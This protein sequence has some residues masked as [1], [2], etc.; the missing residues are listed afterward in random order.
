[1]AWR[2]E[3]ALQKWEHNRITHADD[4]SRSLHQTQFSGAPGSG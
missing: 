4:A 3:A 2:K 1:M